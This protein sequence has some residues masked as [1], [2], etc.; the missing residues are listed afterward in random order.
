ML[1]KNDE[2]YKLAKTEIDAVVK[3]FHNKFP[4]KM[5]YPPERIQKSRLPHNRLPDKPASITFKLKSIVKTDSGSEVWRYADNVVIGENGQKKYIPT[6]LG[7]NG[8]KN[9][10][11]GDIELLYFLLKKSEYCLDGENQGR[12]VKFTFEDKVTEADRKAEKR[13]RESKIDL[14]IFNTDTCL[15]EDKL[16]SLA[17]AFDVDN[18]DSLTL[19]QTKIAIDSKIHSL[20][21]GFDRFFQMVED[22]EQMKARVILKKIT[23]Q[24]ILF[25]DKDNRSWQWKTPQG[26]EIVKGGKVGPNIT[27]VEH[28]YNLYL[29]DA[30]FKEDVQAVMLTKNPNAGKIPKKEKE[31]V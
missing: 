15:P 20:K 6:S 5:I 8:E 11:R 28:L 19:S 12:T 16:R 2:I 25:F 3:H 24:G 30:S 10:V 27:P 1:Y 22:D 17:M 14:L 26:M 23:N 13:E 31:T 29:G 9:F 18:V 7:Y 4:V 21:D